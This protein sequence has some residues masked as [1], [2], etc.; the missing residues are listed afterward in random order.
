METVVPSV[1]SLPTNSAVRKTYPMFSG[2]MAYFPSALARVSHH[3]FTGNEKHNPGKPLQ[4]ARNKSADHADCIV[5]HLLD[6]HEVQGE[7]KLDELAALC[8][9]GLALLQQEAEKQ[10][11][12]VAPAATFDSPGIDPNQMPL[13]LASRPG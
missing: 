12:P 7:Y 1:L 4:H 9:R 6:A 3:S 13:T 5:R 11:A 8:W 10:G 2:L